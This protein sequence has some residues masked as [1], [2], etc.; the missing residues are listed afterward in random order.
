M[1]KL[2]T[3]LILLFAGIAW[4]TPAL[5]FEFT[6]ADVEYF[7]QPITETR[8]PKDG[9]SD[10]QP[11]VPSYNGKGSLLASWTPHPLGVAGRPTFVLVHGG[12]GIGTT[13]F[14]TARWLRNEVAA[15]VLVLDSYWSRGQRENWKTTTKFG[16]NM[17]MLDSV[18]A[19]RWLRT[20][21][22]IDTTQFYLMGGSQGGWTVL[23]TF[24]DHAWQRQNVTGLYRGG[25]ALYPNCNSKGWREDP[26]LGPYMTP[27][28]VFTAGKDTATP[29]DRCPS[30][31]FKAATVWQHYPNATHAFDRSTG[32]FRPEDGACGRAANIYNKFEM[33]RDNKSTEDMYAQIKKFIQDLASK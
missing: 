26:K 28:A 3:V 17:R 25:I 32:G 15:N 10:F 22:G 5:S 20:Q 19:A 24:T 30:K 4:T 9:Y 18:A 16:A 33:C 23:A 12:H 6:E 7:Q 14:I 21:P 11:I 29:P 1:K 13:D 27:V 8:A 2:L 31:V